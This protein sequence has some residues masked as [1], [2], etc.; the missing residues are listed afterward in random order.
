[1]PL[2]LDFSDMP[3]LVV[4]AS[5][6][7]YLPIAHSDM[8]ALEILSALSSIATAIGVGVAAYQLRVTQKQGVTTFE[9]SLVAQY[10][11]VASTLPLKTLLGETL[12]EEEHKTHLQYFYRYFDLCNEQAF[13]YRNGRVSETTWESWKEGIRTNINRP[14]FARAWQEI[15]SRAKEDFDELRVLC[16]PNTG[17]V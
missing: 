12:T 15:A 7:L 6:K 14:A 8:Q 9:D 16:P 5:I 4:C 13:L 1:V 17:P 2:E 3:N 10:R 11:Q